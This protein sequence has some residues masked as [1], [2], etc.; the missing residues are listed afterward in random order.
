MIKILDFP[1]QFMNT[2]LISNYP[3]HQKS[4][5][6]EAQFYKYILKNKNLE[7]NLTY[8][9]IQWTN[10]LVKNS[11]YGTDELQKI[12]D[13]KTNNKKDIFFT[14]VQYDGGPLIDITNCIVFT[15]GGMFNTSIFPNTS[16]IPLP[17]LSDSHKNKKKI[18]RKRKYIASFVGRSTHPIRSEV[19]KQLSNKKGF[20][21][22]NS[23]NM[24]I[25][26]KN[27]RKFVKIMYESYF[28]LC[29]RGYGPNS[30]RLYESF[31]INTVPVYISDQFHLPFQEI[32]DWNKLCV[33]VH[34]NEIY[35]I[36]KKLDNILNTNK[37]AE[38]LNY[39]KFCYENYFNYD[40]TIKYISSFISRD[41]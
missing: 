18:K 36:P 23:E 5:N 4:E 10:Y 37:Y 1:D 39:G 26:K 8:I 2:G 22:E 15:C 17:L 3:P 32:I 30:F 6:I 19:E 35:Q 11:K 9:P 27:E 41:G 40:F 29:P 21:I 16:Y 12:V 33:L 7:T 25:T 28:S 13:I 20:L 31:N 38:M 24:S 34:P 14:I